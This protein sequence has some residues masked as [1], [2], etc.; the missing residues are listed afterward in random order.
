M[1]FFANDTFCSVLPDTDPGRMLLDRFFS[2]DK[3][4]HATGSLVLAL[5]LGAWFMPLYAAV[6]SLAIGVLWEIKD[7]FCE[8]GFSWRDIVADAAGNAVYLALM[9]RYWLW[10]VL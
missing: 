1:S 5:L 4:Q 6:L 8:D 7:A 2:H 3:V 10:T 9:W